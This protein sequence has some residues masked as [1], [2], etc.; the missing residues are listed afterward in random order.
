MLSYTCLINISPAA[1]LLVGCMES[2]VQPDGIVSADNKG[3]LIAVE[4]VCMYQF[5]HCIV[6]DILVHPSIDD[7]RFIVIFPAADKRYQP[8]LAWE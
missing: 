7:V 3:E 6:L 2:I 5:V 4:L 8:M 1:M